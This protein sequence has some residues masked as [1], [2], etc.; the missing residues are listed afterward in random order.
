[1]ASSRTIVIV[2]AGIGGLTA[3]V[4]L[5]RKGFRIS[6][7]DQAERLEETGAG[8]QLTP[9]ATRILIE[10]GL[11]QRLKQLVVVPTAL[12]VI[13]AHS[14]QDIVRVPLGHSAE[15]RYGTP[16]W[17]VH[18]ADLQATLLDAVAG[19]PDIALSLGTRI[20]DCTAHPNGVTVAGLSARGNFDGRGIAIVGADGLWS[21]VRERL[22]D[23]NQPR[24]AGR[25]AWRAVVPSDAVAPEWREPFVNLWLGRRGHLV[26]YPIRGGR[27]INIVAIAGDDWS[28][29][30]WSA[31][32][33]REE[34][35]R[36]F[37]E[38]AWAAPARE[39]LATPERWLKWALAD[40]PPIRQW[41]RGPATLLGDAAHPMLPFL[42]QGAAMA[43]EDA[44]VLADCMAKLPGDPAAAMRTYERQR[45]R[46]TRAAQRQSRA[47]GRVYQ[48]GGPVGF[49]RNLALAVM[50]GKRLLRRYDWIYAFVVG[51]RPDTKRRLAG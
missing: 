27:A 15:V 46:R 8:I 6:L 48:Y 28:A 9:N 20:V 44:A 23:K 18:R 39:L 7:V 12:R 33:E 42:A 1:M 51:G 38:R 25:T 2:G 31:P 32:A 19:H 49:V 14:G 29:P 50:G 4:T 35:L 5:A 30:G 17:V 21:T 11:G 45:R 26:H 3:A 47:N 10:L 24:L 34:V 13:R 40:R 41:G 43:I 36:R 16:Y 37:A 22:G